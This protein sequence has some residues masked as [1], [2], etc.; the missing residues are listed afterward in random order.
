MN[1]IVA[2]DEMLAR[3]TLIGILEDA[4]PE[5]EIREAR[6]GQ[7]LIDL[8]R[9]K[10]P[11]IAFV[12][13][14]MPGK[15]GL[16]AIKECL[17]FAPS[18]Q[19]VMLTGYAEFEYA[20]KALQL[21][22]VDYLLKPVDPELVEK[23]IREAKEKT[24]QD[25]LS[26]CREFEARMVPVFHNQHSAEPLR[27]SP[28]EADE[29]WLA[30]IIYEDKPVAVSDAEASVPRLLR[31]MIREYCSR[32]LLL[33]LVTSGE[34]HIL[35]G[36][37][38]CRQERRHLLRL[39]E[40]IAELTRQA[41]ASIS[42]L[43]RLKTK[44]HFSLQSLRDE[45]TRLRG[46]S[47]LRSVAGGS[48][49]LSL[50]ELEAIAANQAYAKTAKIAANVARACQ[51]G[52]YVQLVSGCEKLQGQLANMPSSLAVMKDRLVSYLRCMMHPLPA[53]D[54]ELHDPKWLERLPETAG[55]WILRKRAAETPEKEDWLDAVVRYLEANF[56]GDITVAGVAERFQ[57]SP[58][59]L[60]AFFH[61]K[62]GVTF[63]QY[64]TRLRMLRAKELLAM[65]GAK[66]N[67]AAEQV[68]YYSTRHFTNLFKEYAG[69][70]PSEYIKKHKL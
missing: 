14:R 49:P 56:C 69:C 8:V 59:H 29:S 2:D 12:D 24:G 63:S 38:A 36:K 46:L 45:V 23:T 43:T 50:P 42:M 33:A 64:V 17:L 65:P 48:A 5:H 21:G 4:G 58:N 13:I 70:Y 9:Q 16:E 3:E 54:W 27:S 39:S 10:Q 61:K 26:L 62:M 66:V 30:V 19:W 68:G 53:Q 32:E 47:Y 6:S 18:T 51:D 15:S 22:A 1:I 52:D 20:R 11:D 25:C 7:E 34:E 41:P 37:A 44:M 31:G 40:Q 67:E 28:A 35:I 57:V 60:S 55:A